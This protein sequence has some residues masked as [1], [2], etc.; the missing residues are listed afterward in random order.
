MH[1]LPTLGEVARWFREP[2]ANPWARGH[3]AYDPAPATRDLVI[4]GLAHGDRTIQQLGVLE[5]WQFRPEL[6]RVLHGSVT[7]EWT[8]G[9]VEE[10]VDMVL[11]AWGLAAATT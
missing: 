4:G 2:G 10:L 5:R 11:H 9:E 7:S 8:A 6:E 1:R 3:L